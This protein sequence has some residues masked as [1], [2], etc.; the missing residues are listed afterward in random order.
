MKEIIIKQILEKYYLF[1][2]FNF[3][4]DVR[5]K[6]GNIN[7]VFEKNR[8]K[9]F[10][11]VRSNRAKIFTTI[12]QLI[13]AKQTCSSVFLIA[14]ETFIRKFLEVTAHSKELS[15]IGLMTISGGDVKIIREPL[16]ENYYLN[17]YLPSKQQTQKKILI[18]E[19]DTQILTNFS[20]TPFLISDV[21]KLLNTNLAL[22]QRRILRLKKFGF[23]EEISQGYP[24]MFRVCKL[25]TN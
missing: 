18:T 7:Y 1:N 14:P 21:A 20:K 11:E 15:D 24:K 13:N 19:A 2:K 6:N 12:G 8:K 25:S 23:I 16:N 4:K 3:E 5:I 10:L 22:A 17:E 9:H